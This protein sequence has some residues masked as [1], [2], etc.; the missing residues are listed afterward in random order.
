M[1]PSIQKGE[2]SV[3]NKNHTNDPKGGGKGRPKADGSV[4]LRNKGIKKARDQER[5]E[6]AYSRGGTKPNV[7]GGE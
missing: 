5:R 2:V 6:R 4:P 3:K 7:R 1:N